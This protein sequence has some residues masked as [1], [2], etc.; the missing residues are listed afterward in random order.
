MDVVVVAP[1]DVGS[2]IPSQVMQI[3][4]RGRWRPHLGQT[5]PDLGSPKM[6]LLVP[7]PLLWCLLKGGAVPLVEGPAGWG[8]CG[9]GGAWSGLRS[10]A[11]SQLLQRRETCLGA[12]ARVGRWPKPGGVDSFVAPMSKWTRS[13]KS[14]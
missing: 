5:V 11:W 14:W 7:P 3:T 8:C 12:G 13:R 1:L 4:H 10:S 2:G 6:L 9:G